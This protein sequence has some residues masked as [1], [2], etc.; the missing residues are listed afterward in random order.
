MLSHES[1]AF[2]TSVLELYIAGISVADVAG[3]ESWP[4]T[5]FWKL[6]GGLEV[7]VLNAA[8]LSRTSS[9]QLFP[10]ADV[11]CIKYKARFQQIFAVCVLGFVNS[12]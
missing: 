9:V 1:F 10:R 3:M 6:Q 2:G 5:A 7:E 4:G 12:S 8:D 11:K